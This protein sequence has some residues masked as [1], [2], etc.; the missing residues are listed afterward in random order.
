MLESHLDLDIRRGTQ[1]DLLS[2]LCC[3]YIFKVSYLI[4]IQF[5]QWRRNQTLIPRK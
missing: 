1:T 4:S 5:V 3:L 2:I